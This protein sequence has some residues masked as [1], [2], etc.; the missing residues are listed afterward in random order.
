MTRAGFSLLIG[1]LT[2]GSGGEIPGSGQGFEGEAAKRGRMAVMQVV[3]NHLQFESKLCFSPLLHFSQTF[4]VTTSN[5]T[6]IKPQYWEESAGEINASLIPQGGSAAYTDARAF[7]AAQGSLKLGAAPLLDTLKQEAERVLREEANSDPHA[8]A[9]LT[10]DILLLRPSLAPGLLEPAAS[11]LLPHPPSFRTVD[12]KR[13]VERV[14]D[15]RRRIRLDP[16]HLTPQARNMNTSG[17]QVAMAR[18]R[19]LPSICAYTL[20]DTSDKYVRLT[21]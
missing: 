5:T 13:E 21:P 10:T 20:H 16:T 17:P 19:S 8:F 3:N 2:E 6:V 12:V 9:S 1:W 14:K 7:N 4:P 15:A 11:E 18:A